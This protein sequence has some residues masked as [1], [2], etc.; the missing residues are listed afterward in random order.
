MLRRTAAAA[1]VGTSFTSI[2]AARISADKV[3]TIVNYFGG[4]VFTTDNVSFEYAIVLNPTLAA[5][6]QTWGSAPSSNLEQSV[7]INNAV[8]DLG[9]IIGGG[10][11]SSTAQGRQYAA[12]EYV[13]SLKLGHSADNNNT[14]DEI[15]VVVRTLSSTAAFW[16]HIDLEEGY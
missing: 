3:G 12:D 5:G 14:P 13:S 7:N 15:H 1:G 8:T 11:G 9:T 10:F 16:A 4:G 6:S 2:L